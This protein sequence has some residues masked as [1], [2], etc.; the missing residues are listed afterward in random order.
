MC[1]ALDTE[2]T[3]CVASGL[4][5][6]N[7]PQ[8]ASSEF[9]SLPIDVARYAAPYGGHSIAPTQR[10]VAPI[11]LANSTRKQSEVVATARP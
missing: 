2:P 10:P 5:A 8:A 9:I 6:G 1:P 3:P 7:L 4:G 11:N